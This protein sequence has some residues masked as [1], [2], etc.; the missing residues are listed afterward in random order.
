[1]WLLSMFTT[2]KAK[3]KR[4]LERKYVWLIRNYKRKAILEQKM[5][6]KLHNKN[7]KKIKVKVE[8]KITHWPRGGGWAELNWWVES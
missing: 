6:L 3:Q 8:T 2:N 7:E 1:M 5:K 4:K